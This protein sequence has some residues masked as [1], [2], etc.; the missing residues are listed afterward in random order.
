MR[1]PIAFS[2][3]GCPGW[4]IDQILT[5]AKEYHY[6]AVELRGYRESMDLPTAEPFAPERRAATRERFRDAGVTICCV[7]SSGVVT[8]G[9]VDHVR[10]HAEL[11]RD[12]GAPFVRVFGGAL[13]IDVPHAEAFSNAVANLRAFGDAARD[14]GVRIVLETHDSFSTGKAVS[15]LLAATGHDSVLSLWDLHHPYREGESIE[16]TYAYLSPTLGH[17]HVK[18]SLPTGEYSLLGEGDI[19]I[20]PMLDRILAGGYTGAI[21]LEWE[22]RWHP[23]IAEP[24]VAFPQY[25]RVLR[26]Y[27]NARS[28]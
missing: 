8:K 10:A 15:E 19:P 18:D 1:N 12:L 17:L 6:D 5:A 11:A 2:T 23:E 3:L 24:E 21:S 14:A 22:K 26:D 9:N 28:S 25:A 20:L 16:T 7:S 27:L 4:D 13:D